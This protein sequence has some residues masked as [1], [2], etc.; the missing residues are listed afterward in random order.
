MPEDF[1][2]RWHAGSP[3]LLAIVDGE[4]S[5]YGAARAVGDTGTVVVFADDGTD[6]IRDLPSA[7]DIVTRLVVEVE[8]ALAAWRI[9]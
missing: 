3:N 1:T 6:L 9:V 7:R 2:G 4:I 5:R 8:R